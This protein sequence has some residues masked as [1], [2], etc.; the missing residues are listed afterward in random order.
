MEIRPATQQ[1]PTA[2]DNTA[3]DASTVD[4]TA[5]TAADNSDNALPT[6]DA[7]LHEAMQA[8]ELLQPSAAMQAP[9]T[10]ETNM[11]FA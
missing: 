9:A 3:S 11:L 2:I 7:Q 1:T 6:A 8:A 4:A 5:R 10:G